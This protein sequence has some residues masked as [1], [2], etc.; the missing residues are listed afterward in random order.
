MD[1]GVGVVEGV[2]AFAEAVV[3]R[4]V[5]DADAP[6]A[7]G[8]GDAG[9]LEDAGGELLQVELVRGDDVAVELEVVEEELLS[10]E[11]EGE[12]GFVD[13]HE[14]VEGWLGGAKGCLGRDIAGGGLGEC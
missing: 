4:A 1:D 12:G 6:L 8:V 13:A 7:D 3:I 14:A 11:G 2:E 5:A 9:D 10:G